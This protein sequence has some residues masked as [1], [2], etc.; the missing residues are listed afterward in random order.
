MEKKK[1]GKQPKT[2]HTYQTSLVHILRNLI[3]TLEWK[4][5]YICKKLAQLTGLMNAVS[6]SVTSYDL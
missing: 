4:R 2:R 1:E 6:V 3:K 5:E